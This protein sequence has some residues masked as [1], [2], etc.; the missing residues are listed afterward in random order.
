MGF[1]LG[2]L[3]LL[4]M[5]IVDPL[6]A[7]PLP[8]YIAASGPFPQFCGGKGCHMA[9]KKEHRCTIKRESMDTVHGVKPQLLTEK[10]P[11]TAG[12]GEDRGGAHDD[13]RLARS[14]NDSTL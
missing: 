10:P 9:T 13:V 2:S 14:A 8:P 4:K 6:S 3:G 5:K 12:A 11:S 1:S 7:A